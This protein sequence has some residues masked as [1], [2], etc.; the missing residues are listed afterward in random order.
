MTLRGKVTA[1]LALA[2]LAFLCAVFAAALGAPALPCPGAAARASAAEAST[3][4]YTVTVPAE[5]AVGEPLT[6]TSELPT[7]SRLDVTLSSAHGWQLENGGDGV[8]YA[9]SGEGLQDYQLHHEATDAQ[10][11]TDSLS[12]S[13]SG[14]APVAPAYS[15]TYTDTITFSFDFRQ[16]F[17]LTLD[18]GEGALPAGEQASRQVWSGVAVGALPVPTREGYWFEGWYDAP[19][20]GT[21]YTAD[22]PMPA[23]NVT[24][25]ARWR[26]QA[27]T[28]A[29][30]F[31]AN[32]EWGG[33][34]SI[35]T[36][37]VTCGQAAQLPHVGDVLANINAAAGEVRFA[38]WNTEAGGTGRG[39]DDGAEAAD[40]AAQTGETVTLYAQW[41]FKHTL[42]V[43][44]DTS[45][46]D[47]VYDYADYTTEPK[48]LKPG[49]K[50]SWGP[51]DL[52]A[53]V[54]DDVEKNVAN[55]KKEWG[56]SV[57][58]PA[59]PALD[60][61]GLTTA[62]AGAA[63]GLTLDRQL[64]YVDLNGRFRYNGGTGWEGNGTLA[65][66]NGNAA[67]KADIYVNDVL[68]EHGV[69]D[70]FKPHKY[71]ASYRVELFDASSHYACSPRNRTIVGTTRSMVWH[72]A[73]KSHPAGY[74]VTEPT[75]YFS[76]WAHS[77]SSASD[78]A[79]PSEPS[80]GVTA[81]IEQ[82]SEDQDAANTPAEPDTEGA[83]ADSAAQDAAAPSGEAS[84]DNATAPSSSDSPDA[85]P[86]AGQAD[87]GAAVSLPLADAASSAAGSGGPAD[88]SAPSGQGEWA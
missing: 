34:G 63:D 59:D 5:V 82:V 80:V 66:K 53:I 18:A 51:E 21:E 62:H 10:T 85:D 70:Y 32:A 9:V 22:T 27:N 31:D 75:F 29:V 67:A 17:A 79:G 81:D 40:L 49:S 54:D 24:L 84:E 14:G 43:Q 2:P 64:C 7:Q 68:I 12:V 48:W 78:P 57:A 61:S 1:A 33:T 71:G 65:D 30:R 87:A 39:Y 44:Y 58:F 56:S 69:V 52:L 15:G 23:G 47:G 73:T 20:G 25:H 55:W 50:L 88:A 13:L 19:D 74:W 38:G 4:A 35:D 3:G 72:G 46:E 77:A 76:E 42:T 45:V 36:L 86:A 60:A 11:F 16:Q 41:E 6:V 26:E 8:S 83:L 37:Y 28:Y